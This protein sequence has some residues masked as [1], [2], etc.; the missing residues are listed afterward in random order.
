MVKF[1]RCDN[2]NEFL[3]KDVHS[4]AKEKGI[5]ILKWLVY[6]QELKGTAVSFNR[7]IMDISRCLLEEGYVDE[8]DW[9]KNLDTRYF[10]GRDQMSQICV[11][12]VGSNIFVRKPE[13]NRIS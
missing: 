3:N 2:W 11:H 8:Y 7:T 1:L 10:W 6:V 4:F 12:I 5:V 13:Q 9:K